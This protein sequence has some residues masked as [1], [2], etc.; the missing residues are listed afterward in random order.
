MRNTLLICFGAALLFPLLGAEHESAGTERG[1]RD[2]LWRLR[3][4]NIAYVAGRQGVRQVTPARREALV[5]A[6]R[7]HAVVLTCADSRVPPEYIFHEGLGSLFVVRVAG[8]VADPVTVGS[9]EYGVEHLHA[10]L[11]VVMGHTRCGAVKAALETPPPTGTT[12]GV[13][14]NIESIL[15]LIRPGIPKEPHNDPWKAAVYGGVEQT[16]ADL[17]RTS[18][19]VPEMSRTGEIGVIG[20]VY[21]IETGKVRFSEMIPRD[22]MEHA[23]DTARLVE[24]KTLSGAALARSR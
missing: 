13:G 15:S 5:A 16:V 17:F 19:I 9:M 3:H 7:P 21:E 12:V 2:I 22:G 4:G 1:P 18:K 8:G 20:A 24:W 10:R 11:I 6:Q 23:R 14:A